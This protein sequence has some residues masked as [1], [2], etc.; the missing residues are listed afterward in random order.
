MP[1]EEQVKKEEMRVGNS[2]VQRECVVH[3]MET[4]RWLTQGTIEFN[5]LMP[6]VASSPPFAA[7]DKRPFEDSL[8]LIVSAICTLPSLPLPLPLLPLLLPSCVWQITKTSESRCGVVMDNS[9]SSN[10][11]SVVMQEGCVWTCMVTCMSL[12]EA[13]PMRSKSLIL[14]N[15]SA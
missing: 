13:H 2:I 10:S 6:L 12:V 15:P 9:T 3:P 5:S 7:T 8:P 1:L 4:S 11:K 14:V